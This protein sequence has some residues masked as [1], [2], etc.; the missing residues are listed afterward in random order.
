MRAHQKRDASC[1][2]CLDGAGCERFGR[3]SSAI[4]ASTAWDLDDMVDLMRNRPELT[5]RRPTHH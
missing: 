4:Y 2:V 5:W 3:M 1:S